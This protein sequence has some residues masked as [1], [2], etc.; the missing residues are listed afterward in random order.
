MPVFL[1]ILGIYTACCVIKF[2]DCK[3]EEM[4]TGKAFFVAAILVFIYI[5]MIDPLVCEIAPTFCFN[6]N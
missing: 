4:S 5:L 2:L 6:G 1:F 3:D